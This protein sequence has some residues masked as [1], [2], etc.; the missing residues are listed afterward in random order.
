[1]G[2]ANCGICV[3]WV[4]V[5]A[6]LAAP[7][8]AG[9]TDPRDRKLLILGVLAA[10]NALYIALGVP[11]LDRWL[12]VGGDPCEEKWLGVLCVFSNVTEIRLGGMNLGGNLGDSLGDFESLINIDFSNNHIGGTIP[13]NL[14][15]T[16]RNFSLAG[17]Q[18]TGNIPE[19]LSSL[20]QLL[21]LQLNNNLLSGGLP[22]AFQQLTGLINMDVSANNLTGQ[23]PPSMANLAAL[24][25]LHLQNN[26]LSGFLNV[27]QDILLNDL[28]I[29]NNLFSGPIPDKLLTIPIFRKDG[30]PFNTT[31]IPSPPVA[32]PPSPAEAPSSGEAP[33]NQADGPSA[34]EIPKSLRARKLSTTTLVIWVAVI[35]ASVLFALGVCLF[36]WRCCKS[37]QR[38]RDAERNNVDAYKGVGEKSNDNKASLR[39]SSRV[40]KVTIEPVV[41]V[42][43]GYG[44][45]G[46]RMVTSQVPQDE[47]VIIV[48]RTAELPPPPL[49]FPLVEKV[50]VKPLAPAQVATKSHPSMHLN[51]S[52]V[53]VFTIASLQQYTNSFSEDNF[54]G[55]GMLG[56]VYRAELPDGK[57]LAVK[58]LSTTASRRQSDEE[59]LEL[60]SRISELR[61]ANIVELVGYC[62]EHRQRLLVYGYCANG[63]LHD[64]LHVDKESHKMF[65]WNMRIRVALGAARAL[66]Y[67]HEGCEP[68][69]VHRNFKSANILLDE[70]LAVHVS[71]CGLAPL[72]SSGSTSELSGRLLTAHGYSAPEFESGSYTCQSDVYSLGV[73]MLEILTGRTSFD[74]S[75][76]RGEHSLVRW[77]I[78]QLH[79][80]DALSR[81]VDPS[82][83]GAYPVKSLS[84]FTD[85]ISRCV[86]GH[87]LGLH[88]FE[89]L[90][91]GENV[92]SMKSLAFLLLHNSSKHLLVLAVQ[93][94]RTSHKWE[95]GFRP[96]MSEIVQDLLHMI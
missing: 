17:N 76:P 27:L 26:K 78:P 90:L 31:I 87:S 72:L 84:R 56:S 77:A 89:K 21:D 10:I 39:P 69:I 49:P 40:E 64:L 82:L 93:E 46:R 47:Q 65:S 35:G 41:Q 73:V 37:S 28:N 63:T 7:F 24:K 32:L 70:K 36:M 51:S 29:E 23:L 88:I 34:I 12:P 5:V 11:P 20:T 38:S 75:R 95:P 59:F 57:L 91:C 43:D 81:M 30:N 80:I 86:Q 33:G 61:H 50:M 92:P 58:K 9:L 8:C 55:Q 74:R 44:L 96:P 62:N 25:T 79:D 83:N 52:S 4:V 60:V 13:S 3:G 67:L 16:I 18:F 68:P 2:S 14:P 48:M 45:D 54:I 94:K 53:S 19:S 85:I 1:M 22:D 66:Q 71:D 15:V 42:Q 6:A